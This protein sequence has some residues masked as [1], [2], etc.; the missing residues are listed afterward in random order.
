MI[1][2]EWL[3][4]YN[5][6]ANP[7]VDLLRA[8]RRQIRFMAFKRLNIDIVIALLP[9]ILHSSVLL[10]FTGA[11]VYV[12][13]ID[14]G[15]AVF[16]LLVTGMFAITYL[17]STFLPFVIDAP[18]R[19]YSTILIHRLYVAVGKVAIQVVDVVARACSFAIRRITV[20]ILLAFARIIPSKDNPPNSYPQDRTALP[21]GYKDMRIRWANASSDSLDEIDTSQRIQDQAILWLSQMPL[22]LSESRVV[23]SSLALIPS[24]RPHRFPRSVIVFLNLTLDSLFRDEPGQESTDAATDCVIA[25]GRI[26]FQSAVDRNSDQDHSIREV[27]VTPLVGWAAQQLTAHAFDNKFNTPHTEGIRTRLLVAAA[28]LSPVD[29]IEESLEGQK[30]KIQDRSEFIEKIEATLARHVR[31][32]N[33]LERKDLIELIH[34]MHACIPRGNYGNASSVISFLPTVCEDYDSPWSEDESVLRALVTYALDL[35]LS[36]G[37]RKPL[38]LVDQEIEF[39]ELASELLD[40]LMVNTTYADVAMFGLWLIYRVPYAFKSRKSIVT[41][42][43]HIW[44]SMNE[45]ISE[46]VRERVAFHAIDSLVAAFQYHTVTNGALPKLASHDVLNLLK[47][48]VESDYSKPMATYATAMVLNLGSP[49]QVATFTRE[50]LAE[51]FARTLYTIQSDLEGNTAEEDVVDLHIYSALVLLKLQQP[52]VDVERVKALVWEMEKTIRDEVVGDSENPEVDINID[53]NRVRWKAVYLTGLLFKFIPPGEKDPIES[54]RERVRALLLR[55][56]LPTVG[57]YER[58]LEP[59]GMDEAELVT[60]AQQQGPTYT[61]F[62]EWIDGFPLFPLAGSVTSVKTHI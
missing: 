50:V 55:G 21:R 5:S 40:V 59:L 32:H 45:G 20:A 48:A 58:C 16:Y 6:D 19:T 41:D 54:L 4:E 49:T 22:D 57:D 24:S 43:A 42:I 30:V 33:T 3:A 25:L 9:A 60:I 10:F 14:L 51:P 35:L 11:V 61:A 8:C 15:V 26:K 37:R 53:L 44:A 2:K 7:V 52:Q 1:C 17:I 36:S 28:W 13:K 56:G 34:G 12:W 23:V 29:G 39:C 46:D 18:F 38:V 62:E 47:A 27:P 31:G